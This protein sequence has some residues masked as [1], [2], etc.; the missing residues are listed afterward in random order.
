ML[1]GATVAQ[2][3]L[4]LW[5]VMVPTYWTLAVT[6]AA[7]PGGNVKLSSVGVAVSGVAGAPP[8][9]NAGAVGIS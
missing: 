5:A 8:S 3:V 9:L 1:A 6:V 4:E 7:V 2:P